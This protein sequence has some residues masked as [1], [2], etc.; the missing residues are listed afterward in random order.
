[1]VM[2]A[3]ESLAVKPSRAFLQEISQLL[4]DEDSVEIEL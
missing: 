1:M 4:L 3:G 2:E